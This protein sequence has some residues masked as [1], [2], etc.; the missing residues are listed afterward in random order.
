MTF[1]T[2][3]STAT[4]VLS[5]SGNAILATGTANVDATL[6][7]VDDSVRNGDTISLG[8]TAAQTI[9]GTSTL[10]LGLAQV[11]DFLDA[12]RISS[13]AV[14]LNLVGGAGVESLSGGAGND[15]ITAGTGDSAINAGAGTNTI[16]N[17]GVDSDAVTVDETSVNTINVVGVQASTVLA[18][19]GTNTIITNGGLLSIVSADNSTV[20]VTM[21]GNGL[22]NTYTGGD[23]NDTIQGAA[24][25]DVL[26][27]GTGADRFIN[28]TTLAL[29]GADGIADFNITQG[30][31]FTFDF[32]EAGGL[33][34]QAA[35]R[36]TGVNFERLAAT[37]NLGAN[38]GLVI[39]GI[40]IADEAALETYAE[41]LIGEIAG[42]IV[43]F[44]TS[45][46]VDANAA[47]SLYSVTYINAGNTAESL[48]VTM[49]SNELD[50]FA[51]AQF[52]QF[53]AA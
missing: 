25:N 46:D 4:F 8:T 17:I 5:T 37:A 16:N 1:A 50:N 47:C 38:T 36:G 53:T 41:G 40:N 49:A 6:R 52:T 13:A 12:S 23:V 9:D 20:G 24:G 18:T 48:M 28:Q 2:A 33:A 34:N 19:A 45:T 3:A 7:I 30:D 31:N 43:Y 11:V 51:A 32:G 21:T 26:N 14:G 15:T 44:V 27:G 39:C 29:N 10:T 22:V 42:D 35:L